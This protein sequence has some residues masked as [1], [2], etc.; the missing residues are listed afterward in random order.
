MKKVLA[1]M[2]VC[3]M[4]V[5]LLPM[6]AFAEEIEQETPAC[7]GTNHYLSNCED[8]DLVEE[9][10]GKCGGYAYNV[11]VCNICGASASSGSTSDQ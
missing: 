7:K 11:Y 10:P 1:I 8:Y 9:V 4:L 6:G 2:L 3:F 5:S